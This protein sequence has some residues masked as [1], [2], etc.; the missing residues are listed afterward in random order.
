MPTFRYFVAIGVGAAIALSCMK[1]SASKYLSSIIQRTSDQGESPDTQPKVVPSQKRL[2]RTPKG[3]QETEASVDEEDD[4]TPVIVKSV[5]VPSNSPASKHR[6]KTKALAASAESVVVP[7]SSPASEQR[8]ETKAS[9]ASAESAEVPS[10][11]PTS[12]QRQETE[13]SAEAVE[14]V[15]VPLSSLPSEQSQD[16]KKPS[17]EE[18]AVAP[19]PTRDNAVQASASLATETPQNLSEPA[20]KE[21]SESVLPPRKVEL[22]QSPASLYSQSTSGNQGTLAPESLNPSANPLLFPTRPE[23]V[24]IESVQ[25]I[26]LQQAIELARRNN[27]ELER[28]RLT[29]ERNRFALREA[30]SAEYP[31]ASVGLELNRSDS[32][33][34]ERGNQGT[35][36][37]DQLLQLLGLD[38]GNDDD[39]DDTVSTTLNGL[40]ELSYDLFTAGRRPA[41]I[42]AAEEQ[43]RIQQ[44]EIERISEQLRL[45]VS[46]AY[47]DLQ[48]TDAQTEIAQAAVTDAGRSLRDAQ[49]L[50]EAGLG[51]RFDVLQAQVSLANANQDLTR[52]ISQQR[53]A[54]RQIVQ[55][56]SL[57]QS[58]EVSAADPIEV[59]GDWELPLEQS[60]VLA[61]RNR[62][63]L[64]QQLAQRNISEQQRRI[65]LAAIRPQAS[66][67]ANY[68]ILGVLD[69]QSGTADGFTLGARV[70]WNFF[71][72][73]AA[74]AR[75]QQETTNIAIAETSFAEQRNQV[76][77][78]VEQA[79]F[80]L[81]AN[82]ENIQTASF[83][84]EQAEESLRLARLRFQ[85]GVGT[86]ADV[87]TQ[88]TELTR[89]RV[90]RLSAILDYNR[91]LASLQRAI[92]NLPAS[93]LFD[94]P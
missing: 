72:G 73:G 66:V 8:Q 20:D 43:V 27:R 61:L 75:A 6:Q 5:V 2:I 44:L 4:S 26:T 18:D 80:D 71:D 46:T 62:A 39:D 23:E 63:E 24:E 84:L 10:S 89:A 36:Q 50:E 90:N 33:Q 56:L 15:V 29:L 11:S 22:A 58:V 12:K 30:L 32:A 34:S 17:A 79:F 67:F 53:V 42:R 93:N 48:E 16:T 70:Q 81:R 88:Q 69:D 60:I 86:Q 59:A 57:A 91:A 77:F 74:R 9:A 13:T 68:N 1:P 37:I 19:I 35:S 65:A 51:T 52:A 85:A 54:R 31:N 14:L 82:Q 76:R 41:T 55:L 83:A 40:L 49:L 87:I 78:Q 94:L 64:E 3:L 7:S 28:A 92:S 45:D 25:P 38:D 47:F 21:R